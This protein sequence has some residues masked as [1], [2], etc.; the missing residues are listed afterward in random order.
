MECPSCRASVPEGS[1]FCP[2]CGHALLARA[3]ERR[4]VTVLFADLVGFTT[5]SEGADPEQLK[6]LVDTGFQR[7]VNDIANHG[8]RV[9]KIVGD[10]IM[11]LFGAPVAHEDD[12][13]RAVRAALQMQATLTEYGDEIGVPV[14]MRIGINSGEVLVGALRA[15]GEYTAMG[16]TVNVAARLQTTAL[17]GQVLVGPATH[18]ETADVVRYDSLGAIEARGRGERV[19]AFVALETLAPPGHRRRRARTPLIGRE[20]E[21]GILCSSVTMA[22][23]RR[24]PQLVMLTGDAG[25]GKSRLAEELTSTAASEHSAMVLEG[26]CVPYGEANVW[27][28]IAA[29]VRQALDLRLDDTAEASIEKT[30]SKVAWGL[31]RPIDDP[32]VERVVE[33]LGYLLG[34]PSA[35]AEMEPARAREHAT[36][37]FVGLL[38]NMAHRKPLVLALSELHWADQLVLDLVEDLPDRMRGLPFALVATS[39]PELAERWSPTPGRHNLV[40]LHLDPLDRE[41]A[42]SLLTTL[43]EGPPSREL[44]DAVLARSGGNP[45][46][47]EELAALVHQAGSPR[48][49]P[50]TLRALVATRV[51]NL[52]A[53]ERRVL[54]HA[55]VIGRLGSVEALAALGGPVDGALRRNLDALVSRDLLTIDGTQWAFRS[56][57]VREVA[58]ET[59]T[60]GERARAHA[61]LGAFLRQQA[62]ERGREGEQ[63]EALAHHFGAAAELDA[64]LGGVDGVPTDTLE[65]AITWY[66]RAI[67][68]AEH[69]ETPAPA[70]QLCTRVL[71]LLPEERADDRR[72]F[73]VR[74]AA[75]LAELR[76][77]DEA[78][79]DV[80]AV[81]TQSEAAGDGWSAASAY[82]VRGH[83]E[84][85]E[86]ALY[87]SAANLDEAI[88]RWQ[89]VGD[90]AG[91]ATA[92]RLR[93]M[94]DLFLGRLTAAEANIAAALALFK[95]L[96]D[97]RGEAWAQQ[98]MA[99]ISTS[100]GDVEEA[101]RRI[102]EAVRLFSEIGDRAG[103]G[104]AYGLLGWVRL[105]EGYLDEAD[106]L[107]HRVLDDYES[108]GDPWAAGMMS[109]L[110]AT[111]SLWL[112]RTDEAVAA[113]TAA[114]ERFAS[115]DDVTGE[116]RSVATLSRAL[117]AT[118]M[119]KQARE[120]LE[121]ASALANSGMDAD[122]REMGH[123]ITAGTAVQL[124]EAHQILG[125]GE[126][127]EP[128]GGGGTVGLP[129]D[130]EVPRG[131]ALLQLGRDEQ[132]EAVLLD[133]YS[134]AAGPGAV[135]AAGAAL[136][137]AHAVTGA[138][139]D[140]IAVADRTDAVEQGTYLDRIGAG[141]GRGFGLLRLGRADEA[142][143]A[144]E[145]GVA[146]ADS[147][148]DRLNQAL[149]RLAL[150][151]ALA[152]M[153]A[154]DA[155]AV[156]GDAEERLAAMGLLET[157][158]DAVF[159]RAAG[160]P[161]P[162]PF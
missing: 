7:L 11:A 118:G 127:L 115:I 73:L 60:K 104:W 46:F 24:R 22:F 137:L 25:I 30:R 74:R 77:H 111:T 140:A 50:A 154:V 2:S 56:D 113:S 151:S 144:L 89:A 49:L 70:E 3:E 131:L 157:E 147:T 79:A 12:A 16:D 63:L 75:A 97:R 61:R 38:Q 119:L 105:A 92:R 138:A 114:R 142:R 143:A 32:D 43:L 91:E 23:E 34:I 83:I 110:C 6:N 94:T 98:N 76:R 124:G 93:G 125:L 36:S 152:A 58:Y 159:R 88:R 99:W 1:R 86:G 123:L 153:E 161:P 82:T 52:P 51:D 72:R 42:E 35:L 120:L 116:L 55:A 31:K 117:L 21:M 135:H 126:L 101:K 9:D 90:R 65:E 96:S 28:P 122:G 141:F 4:V 156:R 100:A 80:A 62:K 40:A 48:E 148:G 150:S 134:R 10:Q 136:A 87:E 84:Q 133:A 39:R 14:R 139:E 5:F 67:T 20:Q 121:T 37:S 64:E 19:E 57:L 69:R 29:A 78:R 146:I 155:D 145:A 81:L 108:G 17:P 41:G 128:P 53:P 45:F 130:R 26:R 15:G 112:G 162:A 95:E 54:D 71:A 129:V 8:G 47:L 68:Q 160:L 44:L 13:E 107:A 106:D 158:W 27:W 102:G 66:E 33:G 149:T 85:S 18:D 132:A 103:L 59:L 109:L